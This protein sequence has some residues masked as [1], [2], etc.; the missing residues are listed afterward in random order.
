MLGPV[1]QLAEPS[2]RDRYGR[3]QWFRRS[4]VVRSALPDWA[5]EGTMSKVAAYNTSSPEYLPQHREVY[6]D[7][8]DCS[9]GKKIKREHREPGTGGKKRCKVCINLG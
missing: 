9:D 6:H 2:R 8:D 1:R 4:V 5:Q 3:P 7:H